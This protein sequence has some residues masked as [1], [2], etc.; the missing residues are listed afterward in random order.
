MKK[1]LHKLRQF[2]NKLVRLYHK[3]D[4]VISRKRISIWVI[5]WLLVFFTWI[6]DLIIAQSGEFINYSA[7]TVDTWQ[8][9]MI[10]GASVF[11]DGRLSQVLQDRA[12]KA[13]DVWKQWKAANILISAD[14]STSHYDETRTIKKYLVTQWIPESAIFQD[15]AGFDT[16]DS[17][18]RA[19][20][21]FKVNKLIISTQAFHLP[22]AVRTARKLWID[23]SGIVAD[24]RVYRDQLRTA[25]REFFARIKARF[26]IITW[27]KPYF[28]WPAVP[29]TWESNANE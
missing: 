23:A 1:I 12:N 15:F 8:A 9:V 7:E 24:R 29:I 10:L 2:H 18:Y 6:N 21:I 28:L 26:D 20:D 25:T 27:A 5:I 3:I 4:Q 14:N 22:R 19:R 13:I 17:M 11:P 16:Y